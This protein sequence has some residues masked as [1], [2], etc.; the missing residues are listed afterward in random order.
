MYNSIAS[1]KAF[2]R[3]WLWVQAWFWG[4]SIITTNP[5]CPSSISWHYQTLS[6]CCCSMGL[7]D[8]HWYIYI[9]IYKYKVQPQAIRNS[10]TACNPNMVSTFVIGYCEQ[11][12]WCDHGMLLC[13][14]CFKI[15]SLNKDVG[16]SQWYFQSFR[17][18]PLPLSFSFSLSL[19]ISLF[20][21]H[22]H[23]HTH[24]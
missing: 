16:F 11:Y 18:Q 4:W 19:A 21:S 14:E 1:N 10:S 23:T 8:P 7:P 24:T 13:R 12:P 5:E 3:W 6:D 22:S 2:I 20:L 17:R 15:N 9:Y